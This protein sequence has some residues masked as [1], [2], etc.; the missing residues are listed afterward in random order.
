MY[1]QTRLQQ[2]R[3]QGY[4]SENIVGPYPIIQS[5]E[6]TFSRNIRGWYV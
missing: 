4:K 1:N 6:N 5:Q 2:N 3:T